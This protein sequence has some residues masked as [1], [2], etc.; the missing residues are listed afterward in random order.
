MRSTFL[1]SPTEELIHPSSSGISGIQAPPQGTSSYQRRKNL[2]SSM[3]PQD[4]PYGSC[5]TFTTTNPVKAIN[6]NSERFAFLNVANA[7]SEGNIEKASTIKNELRQLVSIQGD[8]PQRIAAYMGE[9]LCS[10][11]T[12]MLEGLRI[13]GPR[14]EK[15]AE[16]LKVAFEFHAGGLQD[17][18]CQSINA[19]LQAWGSTYS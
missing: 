18:T 10:S 15:L 6:F 17:F 3:S 5:F 8:P 16:A 4:D 2:G 12:T 19:K 9:G 13:I 14:H 7:I 1:D 11:S